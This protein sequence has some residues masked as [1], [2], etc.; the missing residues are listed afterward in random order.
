MIHELVAVTASAYCSK[1][2]R[3]EISHMSVTKAG[4][5]K[6][7][8]WICTGWVQVSL[9]GGFSVSK[10]KKQNGGTAQGSLGGTSMQPV[11]E[12]QSTSIQPL[13]LVLS[14]LKFCIPGTVTHGLAG[15]AVLGSE[16]YLTS[17][18]RKSKVIEVGHCYQVLHEGARACCEQYA[19]CNV[20]VCDI[21]PYLGRM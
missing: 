17:L 2:G 8:T 11:P 10:V 14:D 15:N 1:F 7:V 19:V 18:T 20:E 16:I 13:R 5:Q 9:P 3:K 6:A 21:P 12:K 4:P